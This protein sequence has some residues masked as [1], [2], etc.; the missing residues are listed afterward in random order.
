MTNDRRRFFR[1][2]LDTQRGRRLAAALAFIFPAF[3]FL[4]TFGGK[5]YIASFGQ[6]LI[7]GGILGGFSYQRGAAIKPFEGGSPGASFLNDEY[8]LTRRDK[9]HYAA[10]KFWRI[11]IVVSSTV[12]FAYHDLIAGEHFAH[13]HLRLVEQQLLEALIVPAAMAFLIL[14]QVILLWT[15][16]DIPPEEV[17]DTRTSSLSSIS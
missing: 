6:V 9:A 7:V 4:I 11:V 13:W 1:I 5:P 14:P 2:R 8:D 15:E 12:F 10:Y 3:Y 16:G 17:I